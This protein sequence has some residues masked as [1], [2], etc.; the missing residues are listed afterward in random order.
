MDPP[1]NVSTDLLEED[2]QKTGTSNYVKL[3]TA[4]QGPE[5]VFQH[6]VYVLRILLNSLGG[7]R[8]GGRTYFILGVLSR[9]WGF[10]GIVWLRYLFKK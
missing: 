10:S 1:A 3:Y 5:A 7:W 9:L 8:G 2:A 4:V 6:V